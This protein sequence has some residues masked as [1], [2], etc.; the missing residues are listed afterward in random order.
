VIA[1]NQLKFQNQIPEEILKQFV[2]EYLQK[3]QINDEKFKE[4]EQDLLS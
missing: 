1:I 4:Y 3:V 2:N